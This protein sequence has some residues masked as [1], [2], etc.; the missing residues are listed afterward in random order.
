MHADLLRLDGAQIQHLAEPCDLGENWSQ[1]GFHLYCCGRKHGCFAGVKLGFRF[2][3]LIDPSASSLVLVGQYG[4]AA[5]RHLLQQLQQPGKLAAVQLPAE[6]PVSRVII[7]GDGVALSSLCHE[8]GAAGGGGH[9]PGTSYG[10]LCKV[11]ASE[12]SRLAAS[13]E[14]HTDG[15]CTCI[16]S[17]CHHCCTVQ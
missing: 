4:L 15:T 14:G 3:N 13:G 7:P 5:P 17:R 11:V 2:S 12:H 9:R 1:F 10:N 8:A 16:T 6:V